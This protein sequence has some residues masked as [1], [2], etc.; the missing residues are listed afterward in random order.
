M[1]V[2]MVMVVVIV[3]FVNIPITRHAS[4]FRHS[5]VSK[6]R[7]ARGETG[8]PMVKNCEKETKVPTL[9]PSLKPGRGID[10]IHNITFPLYHFLIFFPTSGSKL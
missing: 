6:V 4:R 10:L 7:K 8:P 3:M 1:M 9:N 2:V 5:C